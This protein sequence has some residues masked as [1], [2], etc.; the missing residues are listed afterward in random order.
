MTSYIALLRK[1]EESD[2]GV[3]FSDFRGC[4]TA[5]RTLDEA[6][7]LAIEALA[8]HVEGMRADG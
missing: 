2:Y 8:F 7:G 5:G 1:D 4:V 6:M 3:M